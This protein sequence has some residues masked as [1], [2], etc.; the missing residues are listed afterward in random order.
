MK[1]L[2]DDADIGS[3]K[4]RKFVF[5]KLAKVRSGNQDRAIVGPLQ[6]RHDHEQSRFA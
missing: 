3:A 4:A 2:E 6:S 5:V 1:G